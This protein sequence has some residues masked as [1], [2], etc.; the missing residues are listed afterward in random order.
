MVFDIHL[1]HHSIK[2]CR[3]FALS[4]CPKQHRDVLVQRVFRVQLQIIRS[5]VVDGLEIHLRFPP[6]TIAALDLPSF[7]LRQGTIQADKEHIQLCDQGKKLVQ[8]GLG[9]YDVVE[10]D[11]VAGGGEGRD[12]LMQ[13]REYRGSHLIP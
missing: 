3:T 13:T 9:L 11:V 6:A 2:C 4:P 7:Q 10:N 12:A 1:L 8:P 5:D